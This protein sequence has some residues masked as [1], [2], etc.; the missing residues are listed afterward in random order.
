M[1]AVWHRM[2]GTSW[3]WLGFYTFVLAA[4]GALFAMSYAPQQAAFAQIYGAEFWASL[5]AI[6]PADA[7]YG[8][9][10][11]MWALMSAA[12]MAPTFVPTLKVYDDLNQ[13][14][15]ASGQGFTQLLAGY[16]GIWLGFSALAAGLQL[17]AYQIGL[18]Q[19]NALASSGIS[20]VLLIGAGA[21]QFSNVKKACLSKCRAPFM[22]FMQHWDEGPLRNGVRL[23]L[24]CIGCCW[25]LMLLGFVGGTMN[26]VWM[27]AA[28]LLMVFE[29]L[30]E[31]GRHIT[32]PLGYL[33]IIAGVYMAFVALL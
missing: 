13:A 29:K 22:F 12:M 14:N 31:I 21:Y 20:A 8:Q 7:G 15:I 17:L 18:M 28:T 5:C 9:V 2:S 24:V 32:K 1:Q 11:L 19:Q 30:P 33:L 10:F 25:A 16:I 26:L 3:R 23:G 6:N 27:G 4:W